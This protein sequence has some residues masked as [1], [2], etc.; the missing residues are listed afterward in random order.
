M[1]R[2]T[3]RR[4]TNRRSEVMVRTHVSKVLK[5]AQPG[6]TVKVGGWVR[7]RRDSKQGFSFVELND[8]S[9]FSSIQV[10]VDSDTP[11]YDCIKDV[12]TGSCVS[13]NGEVKDS[14]G[15]GQ[16]VELHATELILHGTAESDTYPLQ[17][18]RHSSPS[19]TN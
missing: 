7:T 14:P 8:G 2:V 18:K 3:S 19:S 15:K 5:D 12:T 9:C 17:K 1:L 13:V 4:I 10:V 6:D 16:R 11:G